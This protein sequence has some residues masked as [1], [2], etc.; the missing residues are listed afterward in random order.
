MTHLQLTQDDLR[1]FA[2]T[3]QALLSAPDYEEVRDWQQVA[4]EAVR[5]FTGA[6]RAVFSFPGSFPSDL[7]LVVHNVD[8][9]FPARFGEY[10]EGSRGGDLMF[11]DPVVERAARLRRARGPGAYHFRELD[12]DRSASH[13]PAYAELFRPAGLVHMTGLSVPLPVGE[14]TQFVAFDR[15]D[16]PGYQEVGMARLQMLVPAFITGVRMRLRS[17][18]QRH[19]LGSMLDRLPRAFALHSARGRR[20]HVNSAWKRLAAVPGLHLEAAVQRLIRPHMQALR[21]VAGR[22]TGRLKPPQPQLEV[23]NRSRRIRL[24]VTYL[25]NARTGYGPALLIEAEPAGHRPT[26]LKGAALLAGLSPQQARVAA[27]MA[28]GRS[29][30][31]IARSLGI[32]LSTAQNH[33][34]AVRRILK[35]N[36]RTAV[37]AALHTVLSGQPSDS[38][39]TL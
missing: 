33:A 28:E 32:A 8:P 24:T 4:N 22:K 30:K 38:P 9:E 26:S 10:L 12:P 17:A 34:A 16:H 19:M 39:R 7:G 37:A 21:P 15:P 14:V 5:R 3:Q 27:L 11:R 18:R 6:D 20:L 29:D 35:V 2:H 13:S 31:A 23:G 36:S 25:S 1:E